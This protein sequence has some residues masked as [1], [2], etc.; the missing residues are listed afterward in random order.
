M[1]DIF[2]NSEKN[3]NNIDLYSRN[4]KA[5]KLK[6]RIILNHKHADRYAYDLK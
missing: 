2:C 1:H 6:V 4:A 5:A 3:I